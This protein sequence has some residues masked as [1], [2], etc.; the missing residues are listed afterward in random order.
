MWINV[1]VFTSLLCSGFGKCGVMKYFDDIK[2]WGYVMITDG[3]RA[4]RK[5]ITR[6]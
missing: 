2:R 5:G 3:G 4:G 6:R 1:I